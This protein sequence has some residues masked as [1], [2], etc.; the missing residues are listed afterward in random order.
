[1]PMPQIV[2]EFDS[3]MTSG[4]HSLLAVS[5]IPED[6]LGTDVA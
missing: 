1:M 2:S 4:A 5:L 6:P 3:K